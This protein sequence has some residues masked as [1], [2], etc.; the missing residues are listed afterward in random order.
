MAFAFSRD[1]ASPRSHHK[2][3]QPLFSCSVILLRTGSVTADNPLRYRFCI[4]SQLSSCSTCHIAVLHVLIRQCQWSE[5]AHG[6]SLRHPLQNHGLSHHNRRCV[7]FLPSS[8]VRSVFF[9]KSAPSNL[10][11]QRLY[12]S[13][14][15]QD[16]SCIPCLS[17]C[18]TYFLP[19][20]LPCCL[21]PELQYPPLHRGTRSCHISIG[22]RKS[23]KPI[24]SLTPRITKCNRTVK[25][26]GKF[27]HI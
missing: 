21:P 4:N 11:I 26:H 23:F 15:S 27:Q 7:H 10:C 18:M 9:G 6:I 22:V 14:R 2:H 3:I 13:A 25:F 1:S 19:P 20:S 8:Q 16:C 5:H 17:V 24:I 12:K